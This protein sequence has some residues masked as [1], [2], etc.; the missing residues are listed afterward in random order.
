MYALLIGKPFFGGNNP[1]EDLGCLE[2][3]Y[4]RSTWIIELTE[5]GES[6]WLKAAQDSEDFRK[7]EDKV[8]EENE[9]K[10]KQKSDD[11]LLQIA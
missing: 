2:I 9:F 1:Q 7:A 5:A 6:L 3:E 4:P 10:K 8:F 11:L